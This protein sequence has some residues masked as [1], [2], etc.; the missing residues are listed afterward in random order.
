[1]RTQASFP[2]PGYA[3]SLALAA[4]AFAWLSYA[5]VEGLPI[6]FDAAVREAVHAWASPFLTDFM[7]GFTLLGS[8]AF[9]TAGVLLAAWRLASLGRRQEGI[10]LG[11][12][13]LGGEAFHQTLKLVFARA[14][15]EPFFGLAMPDSFAFP[16]G[17]A[18]NSLSFYG[19][20][21]LI[22]AA[23][24]ESLAAKAAYWGFALLMA[25]LLGLSRV[26]LGVHYPSD[27]MAGYAAAAVW[28]AVVRAADSRW[29]RRAGNARW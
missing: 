7:R 24:T 10:L 1:M 16:S 2:S 25:A 8:G 3:A 12:A 6:A 17:H 18:F 26:Y 14:R 19:V 23:R 21:A 20:L 4:I 27:V 13:A 15:P 9:V 11:F 22:L 28:I 5:V 29:K